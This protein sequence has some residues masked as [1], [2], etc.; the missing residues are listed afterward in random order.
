MKRNCLII[1]GVLLVAFLFCGAASATSSSISSNG[2]VISVKYN[3]GTSTLKDTFSVTYKYG[4]Y[5][6]GYYGVAKTTG[7]DIKGNNVKQTVVYYNE[8]NNYFTFKDLKY[9]NVSKSNSDGSWSTTY[10]KVVSTYQM[11]E[12]TKAKTFNGLTYSAT[13]DYDLYYENGQRL[14]ESALTNLKF[15]KNGAFYATI[16]SSYTPTYKKIANFIYTIKDKFYSKTTYANGDTRKSTIY[17]YSTRE[18]KGILTGQSTSGTSS[19]TEEVNGVSVSYTGKITITTKK[20]PKDTWHEYFVNGDYYEI[21][22]ST[23][24]TLVK[25]LP[26]EAL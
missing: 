1:F 8:D 25:R 15:Y 20:D 3:Y 19:G 26:L 16:T 14:I 24:S 12:T 17:T 22:T 5:G 7:K 11:T 9:S 4:T 13:T 10:T 23:S 6:Y 2:K 21:K 18:S